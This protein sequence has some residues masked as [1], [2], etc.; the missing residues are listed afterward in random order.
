MK[1]NLLFAAVLALGVTA[2]QSLHP[3]GGARIAAKQHT[4]V[5]TVY[6]M[7]GTPTIEVDVDELKVR[8]TDHT[9][10]W[11]IDNAAMQNYSFANDAAIKFL[12]GK[13]Q[14]DDCGKVNDTKF[15]CKD[16]GT[17]KERFKYTITLSGSPSVRPLDPFIV[18]N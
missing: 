3:G 12:D 15:K 17:V 14:F 1:K 2:C 9:I 16:K 10:F 11:E 8:G 7:G 13:G 6:D 5:V 18:N 4:I